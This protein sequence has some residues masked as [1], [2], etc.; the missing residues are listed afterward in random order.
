MIT[1][2]L[3]ILA[4]DESINYIYESPLYEITPLP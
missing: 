3:M 1:S 4:I 2:L